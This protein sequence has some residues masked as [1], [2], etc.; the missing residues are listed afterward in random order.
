MQKIPATK[1]NFDKIKFI[2]G[3]SLPEGSEWTELI[4]VVE[5]NTW[6]SQS[7]IISALHVKRIRY[8]LQVNASG[9]YILLHQAWKKSES[10]DLDTWIETKRSPYAQFSYW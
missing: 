2:G 3:N 10:D 9:L 1:I 4:S 7:N 6:C 8:A 5:I